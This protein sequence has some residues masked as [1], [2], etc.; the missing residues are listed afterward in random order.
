MSVPMSCQHGPRQHP[1]VSAKT[2]RFAFL[3]SASAKLSYE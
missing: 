1:H 3:G 2:V